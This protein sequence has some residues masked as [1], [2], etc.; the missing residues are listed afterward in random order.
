MSPWLWSAVTSMPCCRSVLAT[1][2]TSFSMSTKSPVI[3]AL[4]HIVH[5]Q[6]VRRHPVEV[7]VHGGALEP[8]TEE[9]GH[10]RGHFQV[11]QD[12]VAHDH[13]TVAHLL[14]GR[15]GPECK[16]GLD[17]NTFHGD[18]EISSRHPDAED[19]AGLYLAGLSECLLHGLPVG[20]GAARAR[21]YADDHREP[22]KNDCRLQ[23]RMSH[24]RCLPHL[25]CFSCNRDT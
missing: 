13:R 16:P 17:R 8:A 3:A 6:D 11:E 20:V 22:D 15:V 19:V 24:G 4:P 14:E 2:F 12:E 21:R 25:A 7:V 18:R 10:H 9:A 5:V 23:Q 1:A